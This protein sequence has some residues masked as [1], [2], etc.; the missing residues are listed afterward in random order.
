MVLLSADLIS[1]SP[2]YVNPLKDRELDLRG[3]FEKSLVFFFQ[4]C[5]VGNKIPAIEN[6]GATE[7]QFDS[8]DLSDN[9]IVKLENFPIMRRLTTLM[10]N[11]N[12][13]GRIAPL[14]DH[15]PSLQML[16]LTNNKVNI[17]HPLYGHV[18]LN[19]HC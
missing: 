5:C 19:A 17:A 10:L 14:K 7:D 15:L 13:I 9:E 1:R 4:L 6:L 2:S 3:I 16:I 18:F 12:R 8:I 11:N